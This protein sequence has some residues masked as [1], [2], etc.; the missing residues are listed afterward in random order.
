MQIAGI[1]N[2]NINISKIH[3]EENKNIVFVKNRFSY[4][5]QIFLNFF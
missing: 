2:A 3:L 1:E 4:K 5:F